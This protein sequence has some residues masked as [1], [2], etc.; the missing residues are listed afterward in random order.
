MGQHKMFF[1]LVRG[2][3]IDRGYFDV[4]TIRQLEHKKKVN[5]ITQLTCTHLH[6]KY[7]VLKMIKM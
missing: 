7:T 6:Q 1:S 5:I 3:Y 2:E 4:M